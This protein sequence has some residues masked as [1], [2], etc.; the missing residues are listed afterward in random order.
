MKN[1]EKDLTILIIDDDDHIRS[2]LKDYILNEELGTVVGEAT[3]GEEGVK[4]YKQL[5]PAIVFLDVLMPFQ[6][7]LETLLQ[8]LAYDPQ[9]KVIMMTVLSELQYI[10]ELV[11]AGACN[12][13]TK[14][15]HLQQ[16]RKIIKETRQ[17]SSLSPQ[18]RI[19]DRLQKELKTDYGEFD[20]D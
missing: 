16:L 12:Y 14:P 20:F 6:N 8:I 18:Q 19:A 7:G 11:K 5:Q 1:I 2:V 3:D 4:M 9:A 13:L 17:I 10:V 15:F